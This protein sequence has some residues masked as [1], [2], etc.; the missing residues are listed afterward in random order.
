MKD[1]KYKGF[2]LI[3]LLAVIVVTSML[4]LVAGTVVVDLIKKGKEGAT[5]I[6]WSS[7]KEIAI[8]YTTEQNNIT[9]LE[10]KDDEDNP[11]G[12]EYTCTTIQRLI[13]KGYLNN[14]LINAET[15]EKIETDQF[16]K[17]TRDEFKVSTSNV[18]ADG[19]SLEECDSKKIPFK[20]NVIGN[21]IDYDDKTWYYDSDNTI[22]TML[23]NKDDIGIS[24]LKEK[25][26][27]IV[28]I[29]G[30]IAPD[31]ETV[32]IED[33]K[34][35]IKVTIN[36]SSKIPEDKKKDFGKNIQIC[37]VTVNGNDVINETCMKINADF[38][39]PTEP[40]VEVCES[41]NINCNVFEEGKWYKR[42]SVIKL[43][44]G[45]SSPSGVY[46]SVVDSDNN[47]Q[48]VLKSDP[49]TKKMNS[50]GL[51][52]ISTKN[53]V[54][55]ES[56]KKEI[57]LRI[58]NV[59]PTIN[60]VPIDTNW[61]TSKKIDVTFEDNESGLAAYQISG[62]E[63][64]SN[65]WNEITGDKTSYRYESTETQNKTIYIHVKDKVGNLSTQKVVITKIDTTAPICSSVS[66]KTKDGWTNQAVTFYYGCLDT[67][68]SCSVTSG[69]TF[70]TFSETTE[71]GQLDEYVIENAAGMTV[72]CPAKEVDVL[73]DTIAPE[74]TIEGANNNWK[75]TYTSIKY[76]CK[77]EHSGCMT[78]VLNT[79]S[80]FSS[81]TL[82]IEIP[83]HNIKD[84]AG[85]TTLCGS[86]VNVY[87]DNTKPICSIK[88]Q[89]SNWSNED[90]IIIYGCE[91][92]NGGSG[93]ATSDTSK[94]YTSTI[95][96]D[97]LTCTV[98]DNAGN[99]S[100]QYNLTAGVYIDKVAPTVSLTTMTDDDGSDGIVK[101]IATVKDSNSGVRYF[102]VTTESSYVDTG[103]SPLNPSVKN[104]SYTIEI[105][106]NGTYYLWAKDAAGNPNT[107]KS[108]V[109]ISNIDTF[110]SVINYTLDPSGWTDSDVS[111]NISIEDKDG[112]SGYKWVSGTSCGTSGFTSI[113]GSPTTLSKKET[114]SSNGTYRICVKDK[115][116]I[117][118][119]EEVKI[120]KI[121]KTKPEIK[122][123]TK[124]T[125]SNVKKLDLDAFVEDGGSGIV[126]SKITT[127]S[128]YVDANWTT[129]LSNSISNQTLG[130]S[131][132]N[133]NGT[134]YIW[135]EDAAGN[136]NYESLS[137]DNIDNDPP[138]YSRYSLSYGSVS[139]TYTDKT[140]P[141]TNYYKITTSYY[142]PSNLSIT[143]TSN[144]FS[145]SCGT[146][147]YAYSKAMDALGNTSANMYL[148]SIVRTEGTYQYSGC[149]YYGYSEY[150]RYNQCLSRYQYET[151][152]SEPCKNVV[153]Y[154]SSSCSSRGWMTEY[155]YYYYGGNYY[156]DAA[157]YACHSD[158]VYT[159]CG[160]CESDGTMYCSGYYYRG[161][162]KYS[163]GNWLNCDYSGGGDDDDSSTYYEERSLNGNWVVYNT[164]R[165]IMEADGSVIYDT[166]DDYYEYF[167][168]G[169]TYN[170]ILAN[171]VVGQLN[172]GKRV[173]INKNYIC[174]DGDCDN[175]D[176]FVIVYVKSSDVNKN[177]Y[178]ACAY[179]S[180]VDKCADDY[181]TIGGSEYYRLYVQYM[182]SG[183][184]SLNYVS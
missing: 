26:F 125:D 54:G 36:L 112:I 156:E 100:E 22:V 108:Y 131:G 79:L 70:K 27:K 59:N 48:K 65:S 118:A 140:P 57:D 13:N 183:K 84:N 50:S 12:N 145:P 72:T 103:W 175:A 153:G 34:E 184:Y 107:N 66:S 63:T 109:T 10:E 165:Y 41:K 178:Y 182:K 171:N 159:S 31:S 102:K 78:S 76:G 166:Y 174:T 177:A 138:V 77:D 113:Y 62:S 33:G 82:K 104:E 115:R 116:G 52:N 38:T 149:T 8:D 162:T 122:S 74:C 167:P 88:Q 53:N 28:G 147:Y 9:W 60:L 146:T 2:T 119:S 142:S 73:L 137:V 132:V 19:D 111:V 93:C 1:K 68:S 169:N 47:E 124:S 164:D 23:I 89:Y 152:T 20:L 130:L 123:F 97:N 18:K 81:P 14:N 95:E 114:V 29:D 154:D 3:E 24:N 40:N 51:Y 37:G 99:T 25:Y 44:G 6:T 136:Y 69:K 98:K 55:K 158:N 15:N 61:S 110:P 42:E 30:E 39:T 127:E 148:G 5:K 17:I 157:D 134:Y 172:S 75:N 80:N 121:D 4:L 7:I 180:S 151:R 96:T 133:Q 21:T 141:I 49:Y 71:K 11:T 83:K 120:T 43:S 64:P 150:E 58:D 92:E 45:G 101:L 179:Y 86:D 161:G 91:D 90:R 128:S 35:K 46:Y 117:V 176:D 163:T 173:Y 106:S 139:A 168:G 144:T 129:N 85:N 181:V 67:E 126:K 94:K 170:N 16:I 56:T 135:V 105:N 87:Y 160:E 32:I 143:S 155:E